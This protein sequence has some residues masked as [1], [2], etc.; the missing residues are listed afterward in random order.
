MSKRN[1][2]N[3]KGQTK[4]IAC[5]GCAIQEGEIEPPGGSILSSK[6]FEA[7]QDYEIPIP[8]FIIITSKRH[9]QSVDELSEA[10]QRDFIKFLCRLRHGMRKALKIS[11]VYLIQEE[12]SSHHFHV[13]VFPRYDWMA[14]KFERK[15]QSVRPIMEY[16][17]E[18]LKTASNLKKIDTAT[19]KLKQFFEQ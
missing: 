7:H 12:D 5:L 8:G 9:L 19:Q 6:Y 3:I 11:V 15:I 10:E 16:A 1:I 18:N 14:K 13:W 17:R 2:T 4:K